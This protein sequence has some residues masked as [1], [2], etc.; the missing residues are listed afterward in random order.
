[1]IKC[2]CNKCGNE[3]LK[4]EY[5][6]CEIRVKGFSRINDTISCHYCEDCLA[7]IIGNESLYEIK[8][9]E[10]ERKER[11]EERKRQRL[12]DHPTEKGGAEE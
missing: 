6:Q 12:Q 3:L 1:M 7:K 8:R 10:K 9:R 5:Y 4:S 2:F 11:V